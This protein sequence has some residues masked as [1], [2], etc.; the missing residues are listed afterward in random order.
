MRN[1]FLAETS[2]FLYNPSVFDG[3]SFRRTHGEREMNMKTS[4]QFLRLIVFVLLCAMLATTVFADMGPKPSVE[5]RVEMEGEQRAFYAT[6]LS[7]EKSTGPHSVVE[8][9]S[10]SDTWWR[11]Q[12]PE[13]GKQA[14]DA[15]QQYKDPD[16]YYF[17][18]EVFSCSGGSFVWGYYPP[19]NFKVLLWFPDT[20]ELV[21][22][23]SLERYA[24]E[25][26]FDATLSGGK[27][28]VEKDLDISGKIA[29]FLARV[30]VTLLLELGLALVFGYRKGIR[31][32]L[33]A[34]LVTQLGLNA[35][36]AVYAHSSGSGDMF[37]FLFYLLLELIV[38]AAE[39]IFYC[40]TL[41]KTNE[42]HPGKGRVVLY[43]LLANALS[44]FG[45][46][47]LNLLWP[48]VF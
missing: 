26:V 48:M 8:P 7:K 35:A 42:K 41:A 9:G 14:Y 27:L 3:E 16:G 24:F 38:F 4:K 30:A 46:I 44:F 22:S 17:L 11:E 12:L 20:G 25:S 21:C 32:V 18:G 15:M 10:E 40:F 31:F 28:S 33:I 5:V 19:Q 36:L 29:S 1:F 2:I 13:Q 43:A 6:L 37:F 39:A 34:N 23:E 47:G 45:G